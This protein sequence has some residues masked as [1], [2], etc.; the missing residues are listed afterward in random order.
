MNM[1]RKIWYIVSLATALLVFTSCEDFLLRESKLDQTYE[2]SLSDYDGLLNATLGTYSLLCSPNWYGEDFVII[3]DLKGGNAKRSPL[4]SGR[5]AEEFLWVN[6]PTNTP[7]LWTTAYAAISRA[8]NVI[9]V[10]DD[11]FSQPGVDQQDLDQLKG[12]CLFIRAL[13]HFDML[14]FYAQSYAY[15]T[16]SGATGTQSLGIPYIKI[17]ELGFPARNTVES[18]Y[19]E[20]I[21]DL[22]SASAL[23]ADEVSRQD[24]T[25][26]H[27]WA[28]KYAAEALLARVFLY[29]QDWQQAADHASA[30][31]NSGFFGLF[32]TTDFTT[33]N[34]G[35]YWGGDGEGSEI[36]LQVDGSENNS[37]HGY[38]ESISYLTDTAGYGDICAS[39][40]LLLL[41]ENGDVRAN[42][43]INKSNYPSS[44]WP[45]KYTGRLGKVPAREFVLPILRLSEMY[46][47]RAESVLNGA[48]IGGTGALEDFNMIRTHRG[49]SEASSVDLATLYQE[50][51]RE[52]N[53]EGHELFDLAR[54]QRGLVRTD[55]NGTINK[56]V[57][58][59]DYKWAMAIPQ[60]E[61]DAN[62]NMQQN[63][64]YSSK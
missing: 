28:T 17:T 46:L 44:F 54:T 61:M 35:G 20:I 34:N 27:T 8:N 4:T 1:D 33:W 30:V 51:R 22:L 39:N 62:V 6:D 55:F 57:A 64:G 63:D 11:G 59:P 16:A 19:A 25:T 40:D 60:T 48:N 37:A 47:I 56:D 50:R 52:L 23:L 38:W 49:L 29:K 7:G 24:E 58:F 2:L 10:I 53:F 31:I 42:M 18:N 13:A 41:F 21:A 12:E 5:Y 15:A 9:K 14:R 36:I 32:D 3:A 43:F 26:P 45:T